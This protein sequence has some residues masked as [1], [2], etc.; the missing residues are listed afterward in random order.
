MKSSPARQIR[1]LVQ[2]PRLDSIASALM[3]SVRVA[4]GILFAA[5]VILLPSCTANKKASSLETT[6][7]DVAKDVAIPLEADSVG[8]PIPSS[9]ETIKAGQQIYL[10]SCALCHGADGHGRTNLGLGMYPPAMDLT[11]PHV[12]HW[13]EAD[14]F[15]IVQNGIALTGMPSWKT[16]LPAT[17]TWELAQFIHALLNV[18]AQIAPAARSMPAAPSSAQQQ[19]DLV[20]YGKTLYRQEGCFTCHQLDGKGGQ[21]GPDLTIEGDRHRTDAWLIGHFQDPSAYTAGSIMPPFGNMMPAQ[22][23]ALTYFLQDQKARAK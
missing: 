10:Q 8:D 21:V 18:N 11:S 16:T 7:A 17:E 4:S 20:T 14:L 19:A 2:S 23:Q 22:L 13:T 5:A 9:D 3:K 6:L 15:W 1:D 12:Q